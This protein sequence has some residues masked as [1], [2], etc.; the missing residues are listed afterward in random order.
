MSA[1]CPCGAK[2]TGARIE[3]CPACHETFT[4]TSAGDKHRTGDHAT[5]VGPDRRRCLTVDEMLEKGIARNR[6][7]HWMTSAGS[8]RWT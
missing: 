6:R 8:A 1:K 7:G 4:G 2:W 5:S 3:H